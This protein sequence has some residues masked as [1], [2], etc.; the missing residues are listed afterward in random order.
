MQDKWELLPA[1]LRAKGFIKQHI[2]SYNHLV[3]VEMGEIVRAPGTRTL[4]SEMDPRFFLEFLDCR[5]GQPVLSTGSEQLELTPMRCRLRDMTYSAPILVDMEYYAGRRVARQLG[6]EIGRMPVMLKSCCCRMWQK[7]E[8]EVVML[9]ECPRDPG[10]YF[11]VKGSEKVILMQEQLSKNRI[12]VEYDFK[13]CLCSSVSSVSADVKSRTQV[14][15]KNFRV[16]VR[17]NSFV[18]DLP[19]VIVLK[20]FGVETDQEI[21][22]MIGT[23]KHHAESIHLSMQEAIEARILSSRQALAY[24]GARI[25]AKSWIKE[26]VKK[27][28]E[29]IVDEAVDLLQRVIVAHI[30]TKGADLRPKSRYLCLMIRR[31]FDALLDSTLLDDKDYVGNKRLELAGQLLGV[32]F[33]DKF[34]TWRDEFSKR[35]NEALKKWLE[36]QKKREA[37]A[38]G[39][40]GGIGMLDDY[41][42]VLDERPADTITRGLNQALSTGNW[43]IKRFR[44]EKSGVSQVL[45]R[46]SYVGA[47]GMMTR[48]QSNVEKGMKMARPRWLQPSQ[49]GMLCPCDTPEGEGIGITKNL[50]LMTQVTTDENDAP[51]KRLAFN[52]GVEDAGCLTGEELY[53]R[54]TFL[55]FLNGTLLGIHRRPRLFTTSL[56]ALRRKGKVGGFVSIHDNE[57]H[58]AIYIASDDG[59]LCRPLIIVDNGVPRL[60]PSHVQM[61]KNGELSFFDFLR[62]GV[63]EWVDVNEENNAVIAMRESDI[64]A[65]TTHLEIDPLTIMGVVS[66][67]VPYPHHNQSPRN[68]YQCAMGKQAMGVMAYNQFMRVDN[69]L[70]LLVYPQRQLCKTKT[71]ELAGLDKLPAGHAASVAVMSYSGYDIEDAIIM[72]RSAIDRGFGRCYVIKRVAVELKKFDACAERTMPPPRPVSAPGAGGGPGGSGG[73]PS[74]GGGARRQGDKR[75][76]VLDKD[77]VARVGAMICQDQA[78]ILK[79]IPTSVDATGRSV[80]G[81]VNSYSLQP[82]SYKHPVPA[83]VER[84]VCSESAE[85]NT[86]FKLIFRQVR[87]PELGDKFSSRHGQKGV[88]GLIVPPEDFPFSETGWCPDMIMNP[89]GFPS[90]MTVGKMLELIAGKSALFDGKLKYGTA[91][92]GTKVEEI[93][94]VLIGNGMHYS[95]KDYLTSGITGE[96]LE[97]Y[98]FNGPIFYQKL[99]HMVQDKIHAR[100]VGPRQLMTRQPTEGRSKMGGLR[101]GEMERDC[102]VAYGGSNMILER[103]MLSSDAFVAD[104]CSVCGL[105]GYNNY[106][107]FCKS[108]QGVAKVTIPYACKLLFQELLAMNVC[109][110]LK[111]VSATDT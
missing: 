11:V 95:G 62:N 17:H 39:G 82:M 18:E 3:R 51:L 25:R 43:N 61:V 64:L 45:S 78:Y 40:G 12:I 71:I 49:W 21:L 81:D 68:T 88:V 1:F 48:L 104:I 34:K 59:R 37:A 44:M 13:K 83:F 15:F 90:R 35:I 29:T 53:D 107:T 70:Y 77:G 38:G 32:Q 56:R 76:E 92:G 93:A 102:L 16:Y 9:K 84:I 109:P 58:S 97:T 47:L 4:R 22:Q 20:A 23:S 6:V 87:P 30:T 50:S 108:K 72:N 54:G 98:V 66:G 103:L 55:V 57:A 65:E 80:G 69:V 60:L 96:A 28:E 26:E 31:L 19:A 2:D 101:L 99:K 8:K 46:F 74:G 14:V 36:K 79:G 75:F 85:G 7:S 86:L 52:L 42:D 73:A 106:C 10:G 24:V 110:K 67:L 94:K 91:F 5:V 89:H 105:L 63:L 27:T 41:P 33:E 111:I 100:G